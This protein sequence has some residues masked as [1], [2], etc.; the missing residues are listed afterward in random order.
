M[1]VSSPILDESRILVALATIA[2]DGEATLGSI[3]GEKR[4]PWQS[5][6]TASDLIE[7]GL[8][9]AT[10]VPFAATRYRVTPAGRERARGLCTPAVW[11]RLEEIGQKAGRGRWRHFNQ[12]WPDG[13]WRWMSQGLDAECPF[14][15]PERFEPEGDPPVV[16]SDVARRHWRYRG[17]S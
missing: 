11:A 2:R 10:A 4:G 12:E 5:Y 14:L 17:R 16:V 9:E 7:A 15:I 13:C 1:N 3:Y 8:L 6:V